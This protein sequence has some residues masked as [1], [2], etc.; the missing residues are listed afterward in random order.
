MV[1]G[2]VL[3][4]LFIVA[5]LLVAPLASAS[6]AK[7]TTILVANK[8]TR[9]CD[10]AKK[11]ANNETIFAERKLQ[12]ALNRF[13]M[14]AAKCPYSDGYSRKFPHRNAGRPSRYAWN[15]RQTLQNSAYR[16]RQPSLN[17]LFPV[18][19]GPCL[20]SSFPASAGR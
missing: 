16:T 3:T 14:M 2:R 13:E 1:M 20:K 6:A 10:N 4:P 11:M 9:A 15:S 7:V 8:G 17:A 19:M 18:T 5:S 12:E